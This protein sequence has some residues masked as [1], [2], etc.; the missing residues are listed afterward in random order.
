MEK[1]TIQVSKELKDKIASFG[2][3][4]ESFEVILKRLYDN[5]V[6]KQLEKFLFNQEGFITLEQAR[7]EV[8]KE[9]PR[10]K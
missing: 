3:K 1:T 6:E 2:T 7:K 4:G 9:W 10:S 5:A 8:E